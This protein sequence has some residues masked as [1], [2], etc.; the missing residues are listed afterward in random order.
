MELSSPLARGGHCA[1]RLGRGPKMAVP[2]RTMVAPSSMAVSKSPDMPMESVSQ[3]GPACGRSASNSARV[4]RKLPRASTPGFGMAMRPRSRRRGKPRTWATSAPACSGAT[5][6]FRASASMFTWDADVDGLP[7]RSVQPAGDARPIHRMH[8]LETAG[9]VPR[10]V[11]LDGANEMPYQRKMRQRRHLGQRLLQ[12]V[13]AEVGKASPVGG[14]DFL[15]IPRLGNRQQPHIPPTACARDGVLKR[16]NAPFNARSVAVD[17]QAPRTSHEP[18]SR[19]IAGAPNPSARRRWRTRR[20]S[21]LAFRA[22]E[23]RAEL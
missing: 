22:R 11:G 4:R 21:M 5:P 15:G 7:R 6:A 16:P 2:M 19:R 3:C 14:F 9:D 12:V 20:C 1:A 23:C 17:F 18:S 8:P 10:L 13:L